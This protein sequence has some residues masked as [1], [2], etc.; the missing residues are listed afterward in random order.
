MAVAVAIKAKRDLSPE[1]WKDFKLFKDEE[2]IR[3]EESSAIVKMFFSHCWRKS[4]GSGLKD[5]QAKK[6]CMISY[7]SATQKV[8]AN[9]RALGFEARR[10]LYAY[11]RQQRL[12]MS[13]QNKHHHH[14]YN[15]CAC[16]KIF[17]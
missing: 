3:R 1:H 14:I 9:D 7:L 13:S 4:G 15:V 6:R 5:V 8:V 12:P 16:L 2:M 17:V 11:I 10:F